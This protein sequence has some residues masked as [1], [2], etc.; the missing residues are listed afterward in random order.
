M[1]TAAGHTCTYSSRHGNSMGKT[2]KIGIVGSGFIGRSWA[3][4]FASVGYDVVMYDLKPQQV[5]AALAD[6]KEQLVALEKSG[7]L[8]GKMSPDE[9]FKCIKGTNSLKEC[10]KG[11]K[12]VQESVFEDVELK[13]KVFKE[14]DQLVGPKTVLSSSTSCILPSKIS[15]ELTHRTSFIVSHP[16][17]PPYYVP[18]V[19]VVPAPWTSAAVVHL[20]RDLMVEI[21]QS[22]VVFIK[23][24]IGFAVNRIQYAILNECASLVKSGVMKAE[25]VEVVMKDGLGYRYAWLGPLETALLNADGMK[26]YLVKYAGSIKAVSEDL[27]KDVSWKPEDCTELVKQL[28]EMVPKDQ[29][30]SRR[31]WRDK[32]L[33]SLA[34]LKKDLKQEETDGH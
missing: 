4:L 8:R 19:E 20:T 25:D 12:F 26:D 27:E 15:A 30:Q 22:P 33:A 31:E 18:A 9:Q 29:L 11:A 6:I 1:S 17:N 2:E 24:H 34:K 14:I 16:V 23:E 13:K 7:L 5:S 3:M 10:V 32:R 28:D 21:G